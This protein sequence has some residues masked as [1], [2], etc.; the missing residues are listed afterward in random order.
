ML[1]AMICTENYEFLMLQTF[2]STF[3]S[4]TNNL[5]K[6]KNCYIPAGEA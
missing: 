1:K 5:V 2:I 6:E 3:K 4:M